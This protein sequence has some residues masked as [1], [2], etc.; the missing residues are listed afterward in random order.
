MD[1][2]QQKEQFSLAYIQAVA[3]CA[4]Y[5]LELPTKDRYSVDGRLL[6][7]AE[8][9]EFQAKA[10]SRDIVRDGVMRFPLSVKNHEDLRNPEAMAL[11]LL[12][13]V[14]TPADPDDWIG[15]TDEELCL[16]GR[17]VWLT[18]RGEPDTSNTDNITVSIPTSQRFDREGL[19]E[20]MRRARERDF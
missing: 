20:L 12:I 7:D 3:A 14:Q 11:R 8:I 15:Q 10:T 5:Q 2:N 4:G 6:S 19:T 13:V 17:G 9:I 18:L 16:T 1:L